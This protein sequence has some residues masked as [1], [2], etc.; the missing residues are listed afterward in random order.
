MVFGR[1]KIVW[2]YAIEAPGKR[3]YAAGIQGKISQS[4]HVTVSAWHNSH[5]CECA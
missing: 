4:S 3:H 2:I 5:R 1:R